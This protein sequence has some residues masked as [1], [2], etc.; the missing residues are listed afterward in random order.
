MPRRLIPLKAA[1]WWALRPI[2]GRT[3]RRDFGSRADRLADQQV[4]K[5]GNKGDCQMLVAEKMVRLPWIS[6]RDRFP[7]DGHECPVI[8][9]SPKFR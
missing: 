6:V 2:L 3:K 8:L 7:F 4:K 1:G 5:T 9:L